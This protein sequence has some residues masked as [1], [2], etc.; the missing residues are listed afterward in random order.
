MTS[1]CGFDLPFPDGSLVYL[2]AICKGMLKSYTGFGSWYTCYNVG[3]I[4]FYNNGREGR[5]SVGRRVGKFE[6]IVMIYEPGR[7][8]GMI[9]SRCACVIK[10]VVVK[11]G[12]ALHFD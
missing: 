1:Q 3:E 5:H 12:T 7:K 2:P 4:L 10:V 8:S 11:S 6:A 9:L